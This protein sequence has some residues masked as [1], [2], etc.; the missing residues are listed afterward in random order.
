MKYREPVD[1]QALLASL[2]LE[3]LN[4][5]YKSIL[6]KQESKIDPIRSKFGTIE[7]EEVSLSDK[8]L[9]MKAY[10]AETDV[11]AFGGFCKARPP[12]SR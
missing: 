1:P 9:E 5:I 12:K 4:Q 6:K 10:A 2:T 7:K 11:S 8:M 3:K